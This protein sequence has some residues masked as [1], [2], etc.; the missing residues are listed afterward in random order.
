MTQGLT[1]DHQEVP[2]FDFASATESERLAFDLG[3]ELGWAERDVERVSAISRA[4]IE[5]LSATQ[6]YELLG[7]LLEELAESHNA[8]MSAPASPDPGDYIRGVRFAPERAL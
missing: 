1:T 7:T 2:D 6:L 5:A 8:A 4:Q 3:Y